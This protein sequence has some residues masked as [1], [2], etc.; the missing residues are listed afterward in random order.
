V[1]A[2]HGRA[3][4]AQAPDIL[5][6]SATFGQHDLMASL[7]DAVYATA[8]PPLAVAGG[9][10]T[11]RNE[12]M[13]LKRYP[14][15]LVARAGGEATIEALLAHWHGASALTRFRAWGSTARPAAAAP[16]VRPCGR[17]DNAAKM[18]AGM[19]MVRS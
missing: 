10:L 5:G 13:L 2:I 7:L 14:Q 9:S 6:I 4:M 19:A 8:R 3:L 16:A 1:R 17:A 12:D 18:S 11:A 15:L